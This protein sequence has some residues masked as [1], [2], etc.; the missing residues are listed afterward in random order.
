M[1]ALSSYSGRFSAVNKGRKADRKK[2]AGRRPA[3][4]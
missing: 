3:A 4:P 2:A 1:F